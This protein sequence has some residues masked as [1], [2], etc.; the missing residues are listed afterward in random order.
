[1]AAF[2]IGAFIGTI[3]GMVAMAIIATMRGSRQKIGGDLRS[4]YRQGGQK[5]KHEATFT[6]DGDKF[7]AR[8]ETDP[9]G[10]YAYDVEVKL[11][12]MDAT[13]DDKSV[14]PVKIRIKNKTALGYLRR[15]IETRILGGLPF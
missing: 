14:L 9:T 12:G 3:V 15:F 8:F 13:I 11:C 7:E 6:I 2:A 4:V 1:M 5:V 10:L